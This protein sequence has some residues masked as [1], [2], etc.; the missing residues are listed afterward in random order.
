V[1]LPA[2]AVPVKEGDTLALPLG[3]ATWWHSARGAST[4]LVVLFL[5]DTSRGDSP[6]M[7]TGFTTDF[8]GRT[9]DLDV[10]RITTAGIEKLFF[11]PVPIRPSM[12][13]AASNRR[14]WS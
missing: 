11:A 7:L 8:L 6:S 9:W 3:V 1:G 12:H 4:D 14:W 13:P 5:G 2:E 10:Q